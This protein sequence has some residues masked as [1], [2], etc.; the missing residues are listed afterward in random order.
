M[1]IHGTIT[2]DRLVNGKLV[3]VSKGQGGRTYLGVVVSDDDDEVYLIALHPTDDG[4]LE[5]NVSLADG[6]AG[7]AHVF[8]TTASSRGNA[9]LGK[10][11]TCGRATPY[12]AI[13]EETRK[14]V[15]YC[16]TCE[17]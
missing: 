5:L 7:G 3:E 16:D 1:K 17:T 15:Y 6:T 9:E 14:R 10:C 8:K 13:D 4:L 12:Y 11:E 2:G